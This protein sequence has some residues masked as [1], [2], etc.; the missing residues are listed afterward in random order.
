MN[1]ETESIMRR[2]NILLLLSGGK[3][4]SF[5]I[6]WFEKDNRSSA[7]WKSYTIVFNQSEN[8]KIIKIWVLTDGSKIDAVFHKT[9]RMDKFGAEFADN[10]V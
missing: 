2:Q 5:Q 1:K 7:D 4:M 9:T 8:L 10:H 6:W 3:N